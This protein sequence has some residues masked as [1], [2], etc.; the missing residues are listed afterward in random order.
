MCK[1]AINDNS[2]EMFKLAYNYKRLLTNNLA[3]DITEQ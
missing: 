1:H 2:T 3:T